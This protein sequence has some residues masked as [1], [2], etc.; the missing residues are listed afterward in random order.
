M[1]FVASHISMQ[2]WTPELI[3]I[4]YFYYLEQEI[5]SDQLHKRITIDIGT[6]PKK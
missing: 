6:P 1:L 2:K 4:I 5:L 3:V